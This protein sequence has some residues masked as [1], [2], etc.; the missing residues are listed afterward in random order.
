MKKGNIPNEQTISTGPFINSSKIYVPGKIHDIKVA[1]REISLSDTID[2]FNGKTEKNA[3]VAVY[4]T[5]GPYTD[6]NVQIDVKSGLSR[7]R[8]KW[9]LDRGDVES[10]S[11][12]SSEYGK[13][14]KA[15][16]K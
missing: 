14:R 6:S 8:E 9:I 3:S 7:I 15:D 2:K 11:S 4:D 10:L 16:S 5:S 1:M 12:I 13:I